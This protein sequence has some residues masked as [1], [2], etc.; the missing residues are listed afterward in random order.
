MLSLSTPM[1][2]SYLINVRLS[3]TGNEAHLCKQCCSRTATDITYCECVFVDFFIHHAMRMR[4]IILSPSFCSV[5]P[6]FPRYV[7]NAKIFEKFIEHKL[8][9]LIFSKIFAGN[10]SYLRITCEIWQKCIL[11]TMQ[12]TRYSWQNKLR[13]FPTDCGKIHQY[14]IQLNP[15]SG[16]R[17]VPCGR[18]DGQTDTVKL[19]IKGK[20]VPLQAWSGPEGSRKLRFED[21]MTTAQD[22]GK[23]VS[24]THRPPLPPGNAPGTHFC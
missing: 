8:W 4:R 10:I 3:D 19:I 21:F 9:I 11:V 13:N 12:S 18:T 20:A 2:S 23:V 24:L 5:L 6:Y 17:V 16:N 22:G 7:I 15:S 1:L 14:Q